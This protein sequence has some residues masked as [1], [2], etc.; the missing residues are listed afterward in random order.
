MRDIRTSY[1]NNLSLLAM[2][3][4]ISLVSMTPVSVGQLELLER[5]PYGPVMLAQPFPQA[6]NP[7][8]SYEPGS[9]PIA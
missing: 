7:I 8:I 3:Y 4:L 6:A 1:D 5:V 9:H 2:T